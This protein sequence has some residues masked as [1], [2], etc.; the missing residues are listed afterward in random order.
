MPDD[1][2][3]GAEQDSNGKQS[4]NEPVEQ[5]SDDT[6][7]KERA[8]ATIR[9]LREAERLGKLAAKERDEAKA[10]LQE[11][12]DAKLGEQERATKRAEEA[13]RKAAAAEERVKVLGL[14]S[15]VE[16]AARKLNI[17]DEDAAYRL[18]DLSSVEYNGDEP[19]NVEAL[20]KELVKAKPYL[21]AAGSEEAGS[22]K[23]HVAAT[24]KANGAKPTTEQ[25]IERTKEEM[26]RSSRY[27]M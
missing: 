19:T 20:L 7:D 11:Q 24:P 26:R 21:V 8:L 3:P 18:L 22:E 1:P 13:E 23:V 9:K 5:D 16:R 17:V 6:F 15:Q 4:K 27:S 12:E 14:R 25:V 2:N 10:K